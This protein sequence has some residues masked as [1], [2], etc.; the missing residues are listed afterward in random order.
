MNQV[1]QQAVFDRLNAYESHGLNDL[2]NASLQNRVDT[3][4]IL[5]V[6]QIPFLLH[7]LQD[8]YSVLEI[9]GKRCFRYRSTYFDT[10]DLRFYNLHHAGKLNRHKVRMREYLDSNSQFLEV[11]FKNNKKRTIKRRIAMDEAG[12]NINLYREF[13]QEAGLPPHL[14]L[15]PSL[16]NGYQRLALA[17][18]E[19]GERLTIDFNLRNECIAGSGRNAHLQQLAIA[20]LKQS[21]V[22]R[23]SPFFALVRTLG[24][25]SSSF[26]KYC[27]GMTFTL[28]NSNLI[29]C[30]R[31]K[32]IVRQVD[33]LSSTALRA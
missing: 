24:I 9:D 13:L 21:K 2:K 4:F 25:R 14:Q 33:F 30:N 10:T 32:R 19:R 18:E 23:S 27:M 26:S 15:K 31:F 12:Q 29:K 17:S 20:E 22:D 7:S 5:P 6:Q 3:K 28:Q 8:Y 11:K 16:V 1:I